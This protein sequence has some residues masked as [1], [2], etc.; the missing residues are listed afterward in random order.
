MTKTELSPQDLK[1]FPSLQMHDH[2]DG[3]GAMASSPLTG[4]DGEIFPP[5]SDVDR[6]KGAFDARLL[7]YAVQKQGTASLYG[8]HAII[9]EL[10]KAENVSYMLFPADKYA[11]KRFEVMNRIEAYSVASVKS[12]MTL[13]AQQTKGSRMVLA[14]QEE[15]EPLPLVGDVYCLK[16]EMRGY[17]EAEQYVQI[18]KAEGEK[19][20]FTSPSGKKFTVMVV[21]METSTALEHDFIGVDYPVE[22]SA[23]PPCEIKETHVAAAAKYYGAKA[24]SQDAKAGDLKIH[25]N[26]LFE[27]IV[28]TAQTET[29]MLGLNAA[30][31]KALLLEAGESMK[32]FTS[33]VLNQNTAY[34]VGCGIMPGSYTDTYN[35]IKDDG[36]G[37][38]KRGDETVGSIDY[39][40]GVL[41]SLGGSYH[42]YDSRASFKPAAVIER[43]SDSASKEISINNQA[44]NHTITVNPAPALGSTQVSYRAQGVWYDL[45]D[46]GTGALRG[47][48]PNHGSGFV[49]VVTGE[50]YVQCGALPDVGS[51]ILFTWGSKVSIEKRHDSKPKALYELQLK[52]APVAPSSLNISFTDDHGDHQISDDGVGNLTGKL[53]GTIHY[54]TGKILL[55][56]NGYHKSRNLELS[57]NYQSGEPKAQSFTAPL[58]DHTG[59]VNVTLEQKPIAPRS[60]SM[61]WNVLIQDYD[62]STVY[63]LSEE[64]KPT[65]TFPVDPYITVFDDGNGNLL[66]TNAKR[67]GSIDYASG[68]ISFNPDTTVTIPKPKFS[69]QVVGEEVVNNG[70]GTETV[71]RF[72][73]NLFTELEYVPAAATAPIDESFKVEVKYRSQSALEAKQETLILKDL[74]LDLLPNHAEPIKA[75]TVSFAISGKRYTDRRGAIYT[76][77]QPTGEARLCGQINYHTGKALLEDFI[78]D[79]ASLKLE[80]LATYLN[81]TPVDAVT[82]RVPVAPIRPQSLTLTAVKLGG[83]EIK[84]VLNKQSA[85]E[86]AEV[87]GKVHEQ[88][89]VVTA[90]F[91]KMVKAAGKES[92]PWFVAENV[93]AQGNIWQPIY[94][95]ADTIKFSAISY[96]YLPLDSR[97]IGINAVRLPIDGRVPWVAVGDM[98]VL[99]HLKK[100]GLGAA[101]QSGK[102]VKLSRAGLSKVC[103]KDAGGKALS[104]E[105]YTVDLE[106]GA[107]T[108]SS[109]GLDLSPY[110]M[111]LTAFH[112]I[113]RENR[114]V[115]VDISGELTLQFPLDIAFKA[116]ETMVSNALMGG[117]LM[118]RVSE[119]F[120]QQA[121]DKR[122]SDQRTA[123]P[124]LAQLDVRNHPFQLDGLGAITQRWAI[125]FK[126]E[127]AFDLIGESLGLVFEGNIFS[128]LAPI[129]P[130]TN[131]PYFT[132][133]KGAFGRGWAAR[134]LIRFNTFGTQ[135]PV[136]LIRAVQPSSNRHSQKDG[137][138]TCLRGNTLDLS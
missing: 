135:V 70:D 20:Q 132:L 54:P 110:Q 114:V 91:G 43:V 36:A 42:L 61:V 120:S 106:A 62:A 112:T 3:G 21:K 76:D 138:T 66:D 104:P 23:N 79:P 126:T 105:L 127:S 22:G 6:V 90:R 82:F 134:N 81:H 10:P 33:G 60:F 93:D 103:L 64:R 109:T 123:D 11:E 65:Q 133:P 128:D 119:P 53:S 39:A 52:D 63:L 84:A 69:P 47:R 122:W 80:S 4:A 48:N 116:G 92:E 121:W 88:F 136:W 72:A 87:A 29:P 27:K 51:S 7:Y 28:P 13:F 25:T 113:E 86:G 45:I 137:I 31:N 40:H 67:F 94:V 2:A 130:S 9:S 95:H 100:D 12:R 75:G 49:N 101:H 59:A 58:R 18:I 74:S 89:G 68:K 46:D 108:W 118:V 24:L 125:Q 16:Q 5:V 71:K 99:S 107:I 131:T 50:I 111:P 34:H 77:H 129:N 14:Y 8:A 117:D 115:G 83:G 56:P 17:P 44:F 30:G 35:Q 57:V 97:Q 19:R 32:I 102:T 55:N 37:N 96:S 124:L 98:V 41:R 1:I 78:G 85:L 15:N 38:L 73:R 26:G